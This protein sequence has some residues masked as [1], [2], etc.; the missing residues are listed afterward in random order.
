LFESFFIIHFVFI[1]LSHA[2]VKIDFVKFQAFLFKALVQ[3]FFFFCQIV[4][5][6]K[7]FIQIVML[8]SFCH[9]PIAFQFI[10]F[11]VIIA[12]PG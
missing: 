3:I 6:L 4:F 11:S 5:L 1:I 7:A 9:L 10:H 12:V 2:V 8:K